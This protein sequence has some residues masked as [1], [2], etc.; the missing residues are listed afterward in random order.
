MITNRTSTQTTA[1]RTPPRS[2]RRSVGFE[3]EVKKAFQFNL[4]LVEGDRSSFS[5]LMLRVITAYNENQGKAKT[6]AVR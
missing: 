2:I 6:K 3:L 1:Q 5:T 4:D